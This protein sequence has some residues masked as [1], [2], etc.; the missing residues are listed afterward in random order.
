[1]HVANIIEENEKCGINIG[2]DDIKLFYDD[3]I[4]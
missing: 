2:K 4:L 3:I 1:M